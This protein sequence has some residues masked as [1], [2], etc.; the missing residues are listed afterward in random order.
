[1]NEDFNQQ[2]LDQIRS[3]FIKL[4]SIL[5][6]LGFT[7]RPDTLI[8]R[9]LDSDEAIPLARVSIPIILKEAIGS[10]DR[11]Y[12]SFIGSNIDEF[13]NHF[14]RIF[15]NGEEL[16][17]RF[18]LRRIEAAKEM[19]VFLR[20]IDLNRIPSNILTPSGYVNIPE[21]MRIIKMQLPSTTL[22]PQSLGELL[23]R[24]YD[25]VD[26]LFEL[27]NQM[28]NTPQVYASFDLLFEFELFETDNEYVA[29]YTNIINAYK[30]NLGVI[31][32]NIVSVKD[33]L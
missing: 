25:N 23:N 11:S 30:N 20:D 2:Q 13:R 24:K 6:I 9:R 8:L 32:P 21:L 12:T 29:R 33:F 17:N 19:Q 1:M 5:E 26:N 18:I 31:P 27:F 10:S 16:F 3:S 7:A 22:T 15:F 28:K 4:V 14:I